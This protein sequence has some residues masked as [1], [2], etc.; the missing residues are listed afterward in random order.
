MGQGGGVVDPRAAGR[1]AEHGRQ[2]EGFAGGRRRFH[3]IRVCTAEMGM[4]ARKAVSY[5]GFRLNKVDSGGTGWSCV[6]EAPERRGVRP[7]FLISV[8][9]GGKVLVCWCCPKAP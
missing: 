4:R 2:R 5:W 1:L 8:R 7:R 6:F 9:H 3:P